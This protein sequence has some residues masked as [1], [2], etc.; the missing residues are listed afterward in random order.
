ME[1]NRIA[2]FLFNKLLFTLSSHHKNEQMKTSGN[3]SITATTFSGLEEILAFEIKNLG[4]GNIKTTRRAVTFEGDLGFLYKANLSLRTA[5]RILVPI[6]SFRAANEKQLYSK[7]RKVNWNDYIKP[8][9]T[10]AI[11]FAGNS[12]VF[13]HSQYASQVIKDAIVDR[14]RNDQG[15]RPSIDR[16]NPDIRIN[17]L[18]NGDKIVLSLDSSGSPLFKRGYR[19]ETGIAPI[20]EVLAAGILLAADWNGKGHYLDP[21]CGSGTFLIEAAMIACQIPP[22]LNRKHFAFMN[23]PSYD[24]ELFHFI[25]ET[26]I[27]RIKNPEGEIIGYDTDIEV[28]E[29]AQK[30]INQ[31]GL[32]DFIT[33]KKQDFFESKKEHFPVLLVFNPPYNERIETNNHAF[34]QKIGDTLKQHYPNTWTWFITSDFEALKHVGLRASKRIPLYNGK[35]ECKLVKYELYEGSKKNKYSE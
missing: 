11:D 13:R 35:L 28:L 17:L 8:D 26:R 4:G 24:T 32:S 34:Y 6:K 1:S 3:F 20:N 33:L 21:M 31:A 23:W 5:L 14:I 30:N 19:I 9:Q 12:D 7:T 18:I 25:K 22:Q 29:A 15:V 16:N 27:N 2:I 10:I